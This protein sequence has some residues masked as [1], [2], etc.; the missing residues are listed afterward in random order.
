MSTSNNQD[1]SLGDIKTF[2]ANELAR[3]IEID[4]SEIDSNV[5]FDRFGLDSTQAV[6]MSDNIS[7]WVGKEVDPTI[8]YDFST[9]N[10]LSEHL[11]ESIQSNEDLIGAGQEVE[12]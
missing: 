10:A 5:A 1:K 11:L 9:I 4:P 2:L 6:E 3:L 8:L 12:A 7:N